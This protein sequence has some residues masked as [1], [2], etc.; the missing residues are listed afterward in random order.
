MGYFIAIIALLIVVPLV[1]IMLSRRTTNA[2]GAGA[3]W[4]DRGVTVSRLAAEE[5]TPRADAINQ[6]KPSVCGFSVR[7]RLA[8]I[9]EG[10]KDGGAEEGRGGGRLIGET[11]NRWRRRPWERGRLA[12]RLMVG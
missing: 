1:L 7:E 10:R 6:P 9:A 4:R 2:G 5:T 11:V 3:K 12:R 8:A